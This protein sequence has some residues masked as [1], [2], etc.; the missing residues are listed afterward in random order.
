MNT[1]P[2][3]LNCANCLM[4]VR[5]PQSTD[6]I[7]PNGIPFDTIWVCGGCGQVNKMAVTGMVK[8][9]E[10]EFALLDDETK[11]EVAYALRQVH[12]NQKN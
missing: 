10:E 6:R 12:F 8:V 4:E 2:L 1:D 5:D 9:T 3:I 11:T 7:L